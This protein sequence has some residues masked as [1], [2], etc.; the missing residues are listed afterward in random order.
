MTS[1]K[2]WLVGAGPGDPGLLT[3]KGAQALAECDVVLYDNLVSDAI[4]Q[5]A[6]PYCERIF[7]GKRRARHTMPQAEI[8]ALMTSK[9]REGKNVVRLKGGDVFVF[10]RGGEEAAALAA[11]GIAFEIVPGVSSALAVPA[12][13][14]IPVTHRDHNT[15]FTVVSGHED[16]SAGPTSLDYDRLA[17]PRQTL[18]FMMA[19]RNLRAIARRLI[20]AGLPPDHPVAIV[21]EGTRPEQQTIVGELS[22]IADEAERMEFTAPAVIVIGTV[23]IERTRILRNGAPSSEQPAARNRVG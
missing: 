5:L 2:V 8:I 1:G 19:M 10:A 7:V 14:G 23:V 6:A 16:P 12:A 17:D 4:L 21:R 11:A 13:A 15:T 22:T 3:I 20:E 18:I 9:A